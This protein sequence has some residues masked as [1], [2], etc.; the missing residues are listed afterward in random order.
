MSSSEYPYRLP[1]WP[2]CRTRAEAAR[3][4]ARWMLRNPGP[5]T[6]TS[7]TPSARRSRGRRISATWEGRPPGIPGE[8]ERDVGGVVPGTP[9]P[10]GRDNGTHGNGHAQLPVVDS[11]PHRAQ[12]G[13]GELD[14]GHGTRVGEEGVGRRVDKGGV[15]GCGRGRR[16]CGRLRALADGSGLQGADCAPAPGRPTPR[17]RSPG[18]APAAPGRPARA[19][20]DRTAWQERHRRRRRARSRPRTAYRH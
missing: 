19:P 1:S 18:A 7:A 12:H 14:G 17:H 4:S 2:I 8:L 5:L 10:R 6:T 9:G 20:R 3:S 13:T 16:G 15:S 11:G